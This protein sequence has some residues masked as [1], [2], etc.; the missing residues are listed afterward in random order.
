MD[1][2]RV[3]VLIFLLLFIFSSPDPQQ[4]ST[5]FRPSFEEERLR[6]QHALGVLRNS[7]YGDLD[8]QHNR[9]LNLTG[10]K[11]EDGYRWDFLPTA[12]ELSNSQFAHATRQDNAGQNADATSTWDEDIRPVYQHVSG[13]LRGSFNRVHIK[14]HGGRRVNLVPVTRQYDYGFSTFMRNVTDENGEIILQLTERYG[15]RQDTR[16]N[17]VSGIVTAECDS[18]PGTGWQFSLKGVHFPHSGTVIMTTSSEKFDGLL[19]LPHF[20]LTDKD[21]LSSRELLAKTLSEKTIGELELGTAP[22]FAAPS[23]ECVVWLQQR[24]VQFSFGGLARNKTIDLIQ[25]IENELHHP[26]GLSIGDPPL[27]GFSAV[28]FS[29]DCGFMLESSVLTGVKGEVYRRLTTRLL[30]G[31][32][33]L[34]GMQIALLKRQM[35]L[36]S[37]PSSRSR[38]AY[39]TI[40]I[41]ALGDGLLFSAL[42]GLLI[43]GDSSFLIVAATTFLCCLNVAFLEV[44]F[45]FDL[46]TVQVGEPARRELERRPAPPLQ[47]APRPLPVSADGT[48]GL[49]LPAQAGRTTPDGATPTVFTPDHDID[50]AQVADDQT[51]ARPNA[52]GPSQAPTFA[53]LYS[54]FYFSLIFLM[55]LSL[56]VA[57]WPQQLRSAY[58][59]LLCFA[60]LSFWIPQ[61]YRNIMRNCRRALGWEFVIGTTIV[62]LIPILYWYIDDKNILSVKTGRTSA[63]VLTCWVLLQL[64]LLASQQFL[65]PRIFVKNA[66]CP[67]A[68]DYHP[69]LRE[70]ADEESGEMLPV[71]FVASASEARSSE[72]KEHISRIF[73][74]AICMNEIEVPI[75]TQKDSAAAHRWLDQWRY[76]VTPCRHIFH[77]DCLEGWMDLRLICPICR[78]SLPPL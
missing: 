9:W 51:T 22:A 20:A 67:P 58:S 46:W 17:Q 73:D 76:M 27:L 12:Q 6:R 42:I 25:Q 29:P 24:P 50:T 63:L 55:F 28:V 43:V 53:S 54:R 19:A 72:G 48:V 37:T 31:F 74:C 23:C 7:S 16:A 33:L 70:E 8:E 61:I 75:A 11:V 41:M 34:L 1:G 77:R 14:D 39:Q 26:E 69:I 35:E 49:P 15:S 38:I 45:L 36:S 13:E 62:R 21:F 18:A 52:T 30:I 71:G 10:F 3:L 2:P 64:L 40:G 65:G 32:V 4:F 5:P 60:Y 68:Y 44:R 78:E 56:W 59:N 66:W 47:P 57:S